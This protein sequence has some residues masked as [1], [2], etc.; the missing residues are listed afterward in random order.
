MRCNLIDRSSTLG[1]LFPSFF[2]IINNSAMNALA[3][4]QDISVER[5]L[6]SRMVGS[7]KMHLN[8]KT[9]Q[10]AFR[11]RSS[12]FYPLENVRFLSLA[13]SPNAKDHFS[14]LMLIS[15]QFPQL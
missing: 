10:V 12:E 11:Q 5:I 8:L 3:W 14:M 7:K 1:Y 15:F 9:L 13:Q 4:V 6:E 2:I